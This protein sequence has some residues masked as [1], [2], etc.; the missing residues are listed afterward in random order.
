MKVAVS[1]PDP[2]FAEAEALARRMKLSRSKLYAKALDAF[3]AEHANDDLT[4]IAN[5]IAEM[6]DDEDL[7]LFR[8]A[9]ARTV[10]KNSEW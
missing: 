5:I 7:A 9:S 4:A 10:L 2:V 3:V 1:I 6:N 8:R